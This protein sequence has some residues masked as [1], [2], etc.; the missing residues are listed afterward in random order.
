MKTPRHALFQKAFLAAAAFLAL[1]PGSRAAEIHGASTFY[2][3]VQIIIWTPSPAIDSLTVEA[4]GAFPA[5]V[6]QYYGLA[7]SNQL[8]VSGVGVI[9]G[10]TDIAISNKVTI[11]WTAVGGAT[12]YRV[13]RGTTTNLTEYRFTGAAAVSLVDLGTDVW[14]AAAPANTITNKPQLSIPFPSTNWNEAMNRGWILSNVVA[15]S[16]WATF[17]ATDTVDLDGNIIEGGTIRADWTDLLNRPAN[18]D[19]AAAA[20]AAFLNATAADVMTNAAGV[21]LMVRNALDMV[22][23]QSS[24]S[25]ATV[26]IFG[27]DTAEL[28]LNTASGGYDWRL[29]VDDTGLLTL[30]GDEGGDIYFEAESGSFRVNSLEARQA[31]VDIGLIGTRFGTAFLNDADVAENVLFTQWTG[32]TNAGADL[33]VWT[34]GNLYFGT[35]Q[36]LTESNTTAWTG[37]KVT[38]FDADLLDGLDGAT[39]DQSAMDLLATKGEILTHSGVIY[40]NTPAPTNSNMML[41][42]DLASPSGWDAQTLGELPFIQRTG[43]NMS[44]PFG[45]ALIHDLGGHVRFDVALGYTR[46]N[47]GINTIQNLQR[48]LIDSSGLAALDWDNRTFL[49]DWTTFTTNVVSGKADTFETATNYTAIAS[50]LYGGTI[51]VTGASTQTFD[52]VFDGLHTSHKALAAVVVTITPPA[53]VAILLNTS[54]LDVGESIISS[55]TLG[56]QVTFIGRNATNLVVMGRRGTWVEE[57]P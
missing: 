31:G 30:G 40:T 51:F 47:A 19:S 5:A 24:N 36:V 45:V 3:D 43:D 57:T 53:A 32:A 17:P 1:V 12:G 33:A 13:Y 25:I 27:A 41:V 54:W 4:G 39:V 52:S 55:G 42:S 56:D 21:S 26:S 29:W 38:G 7:V 11:G 16:A 35:G 9:T 2:D 46:D 10:R 37:A 22:F 34:N 14:T 23:L 44:G 49:G 28:L 18:L 8:G 48:V 6:T 50:Q 20:D 15:A